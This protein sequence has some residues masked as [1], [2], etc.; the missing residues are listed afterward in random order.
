[1]IVKIS[2]KHGQ[3]PAEGFLCEYSFGR[4]LIGIFCDRVI[5]LPERRSLES[6]LNSYIDSSSL[7]LREE[8][9]T[10]ISEKFHIIDSNLDFLMKIDRMKIL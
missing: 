1:L 9:A 7:L 3:L 10:E 4:L 8:N 5:L 2:Q 6:N